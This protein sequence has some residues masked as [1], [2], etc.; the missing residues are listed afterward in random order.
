MP[1]ACYYY[2]EFRRHF[3]VLHEQ[4]DSN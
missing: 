3:E 2:L 1:L 4:T